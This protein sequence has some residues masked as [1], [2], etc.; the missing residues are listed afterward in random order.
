MC[1]EK[2]KEEKIKLKKN[3]VQSAGIEY[4]VEVLKWDYYYIR[5]GWQDLNQDDTK[6]LC[7]M[8]INKDE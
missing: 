3:A 5:L 6:K 8:C 7:K 4:G 2:L 1:Q